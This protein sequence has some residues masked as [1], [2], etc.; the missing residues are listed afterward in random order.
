MALTQLSLF[1]RRSPFRLGIVRAIDSDDAKDFKY[2]AFA[3]QGPQ[4]G[5]N[6]R[7]S[8]LPKTISSREWICDNT[9]T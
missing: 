3:C 7:D 2:K 6:Q 1:R 4:G 8:P 9:K 5:A